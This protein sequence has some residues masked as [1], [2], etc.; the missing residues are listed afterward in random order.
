MHIMASTQGQG[1]SQYENMY[2]DFHYKDKT[3]LRSYYFSN[4]DDSTGKHNYI[5]TVPRC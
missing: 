2:G 5:V 4:G 1:P 3:V